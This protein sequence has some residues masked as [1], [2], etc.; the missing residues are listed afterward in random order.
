MAEGRASPVS[1]PRFTAL[2]DWLR[3]Q[4]TLNPRSIDLGLERILPLARRLGLLREGPPAIVVAGTNGKGSS[5]AF[6]RTI[7]ESAGLRVGVYTS[8]HLLRYNERIVRLGRPTPDE[9]IC[10]AFAAIDAVR[11]DTALTYFEF[12]TLAALWVFAAH[13]LD[14]R[15]LEV[16]LGGRLDA[17]NVIDADCALITAIDVDHEAWLGS[18]RE[19]IAAEKAAVMRAGRFAV[20]AE[21]NAPQALHRHAAAVGARA[22]VAGRD[23]WHEDHPPGWRWCNAAGACYTLPTP[24]LAG[25]HQVDNAAGALAVVEALQGSL[26]VDAEHAARGV[27]GARLAGRATRVEGDVTTILDVAHNPAG[28]AILADYL[29]RE[30]GEG[31]TR[32]VIGMMHDK[33]H[34]E[35]VAALAGVVNGWFVADLPDPRALPGPELAHHV[36]AVTGAP[37][38]CHASVEDA[39]SACRACSAAND[40]IVVCG[41]FVTVAEALR[42]VPGLAASAGEI[43]WTTS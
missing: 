33:R 21:R 18:D 13:D 28:A 25:A 4:D 14:V 7:Y 32:V 20:F 37:T 1:A 31:R 3:W 23:F 39:Y 17:V 41:S 24:G 11:G 36:H 30:A 16:G 43:G 9:E 19:T 40:R 2:A 38:R 34:R 8:P 12:G 10:E 5:A 15:I 42:R 26:P 22:I 35:V 29:R 27:G 6:L